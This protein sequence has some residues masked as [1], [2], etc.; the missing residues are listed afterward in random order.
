MARKKKTEDE[1]KPEP[2]NLEILRQTVNE[3]EQRV[4]CIEAELSAMPPFLK[5]KVNQ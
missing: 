5:P 3:L 4:A 1:K 2:S